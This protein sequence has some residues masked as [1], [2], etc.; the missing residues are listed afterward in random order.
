MFSHFI[1][2]A[3]TLIWNGPLGYYEIKRYAHGTLALGRLFAARSKGKA[4]GVVGG[5]ETI[6]ALAQTGM[7]QDVDFVSVGGGAM[8]EYLGGKELPGIEALYR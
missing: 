4:F 6:D 3:Q 8:L 7:T 1:K 5:G 2:T